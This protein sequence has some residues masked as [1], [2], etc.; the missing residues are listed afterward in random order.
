MEDRRW[1]SRV[2]AVHELHQDHGGGGRI[3]KSKEIRGDRV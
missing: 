1:I 2:N 3:F